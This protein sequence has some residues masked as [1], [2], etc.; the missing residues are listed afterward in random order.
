MTALASFGN[1]SLVGIMA[2]NPTR[3]ASEIICANIE[4]PFM[5]FEYNSFYP[6]CGPEWR[7]TPERAL[8]YTLGSWIELWRYIEDLEKFL[9]FSMFFA[10]HATLAKATNYRE[11]YSANIDD[12]EIR[13]LR[14][15]YESEGYTTQKPTARLASI[16]CLAALYSTQLIILINFAVYIW[17]HP[18]WTNG[19]DSFS[20]ARLIARLDKG[21]LEELAGPDEGPELSKRRLSDEI[22]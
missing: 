11:D 18:T 16:I 7:D 12:E 1:Q 3:L 17:R 19:L 22:E 9:S 21:S 14:L 6:G 2:N 4:I 10:N 20:M 5:N 15:I 13:P 8:S